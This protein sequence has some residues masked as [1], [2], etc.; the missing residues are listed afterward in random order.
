MR[1]TVA[2]IA[3]QAVVRHGVA[4]LLQEGPE[5]LEVSI[6]ARVPTDLTPFAVAVIDQRLLAPDVAMAI[7]AVAPSCAVLPLVQTLSGP[8]LVAL[9]Q[10]SPLGFISQDEDA[11]ELQLG[12]SQ[13]LTGMRHLPVAA[14]AALAEAAL[15]PTEPHAQLTAREIE[16]LALAAGGASTRSIGGSLYISEST[17][18]TYLHRAYGKLAV[19]N[20]AAAVAK[21]MSLGMIGFEPFV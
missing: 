15:R 12:V 1:E 4:S 13:A 17:A 8:R 9:V 18:K 21:L 11:Q 14:L 20:R 5:R 10:A 16:V 2:V 7:E 6:L 19:T 3:P